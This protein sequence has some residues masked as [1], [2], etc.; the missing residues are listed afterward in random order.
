MTTGSTVLTYEEVRN[1][2]KDCQVGDVIKITVQKTASRQGTRSGEIVKVP[3][4][5]LRQ[6]Y[7]VRWNDFMSQDMAFPEDGK[8]KGLRETRYL[9]IVVQK[10]DPEEGGTPYREVCGEADGETTEGWQHLCRKLE[11]Q[12]AAANERTTRREHELQNLLAAQHAQNE[13]IRQELRDISQHRKKKKDIELSSDSDSSASS[14]D[15]TTDESDDDDDDVD[16]KCP[17]VYND[18]TKWAVAVQGDRARAMIMEH[19]LRRRYENCTKHPSEK[20]VVEDIL[21]SLAAFIE[22]VRRNPYASK[23]KAFV[24]GIRVALG[25]LDIQERRK[26][27]QSNAVV[28]AVQETYANAEEPSWKQKAEKKA[29]AK[30]KLMTVRNEGKA[31]PKPYSILFKSAPSN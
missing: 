30:V 24:K 8:A 27:G 31:S 21:N 19:A 11:E 4:D 9:N 25:R 12:I 17:S 18:P 20:H 1:V 14:P 28:A 3:K 7:A 13:A 2:L 15:D 26:L 16:P 6:Y 29:C 22:V 5:R 10:R 23:D